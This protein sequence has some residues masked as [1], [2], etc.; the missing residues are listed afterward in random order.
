MNR[1]RASMCPAP[2][3]L[4]QCC[5]QYFIVKLIE[6]NMEKNGYKPDEDVWEDTSEG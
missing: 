3:S 1:E 4:F 5:F 2:S 6:K